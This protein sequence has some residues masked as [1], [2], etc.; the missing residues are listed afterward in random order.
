M[1]HTTHTPDPT[2]EELEKRCESL[3]TQNLEL[4]KQKAE[5]EAKLRW[6]QEQ[7]RLHQQRQFGA[8]SE[9]TDRDQLELNLFNEAETEANPS[10]PEPTLETITYERKKARGH[11]EVLLENLPME[12]I[13]YHLSPEE[14]VCSCCGGSLHEMS[15]EVRQELKIIPAQAKVVKHVR[16]VYACRHCERH[17]T[18]T[19]IVTAPMPTPVYR[20][21]LASPS[22]LAY[23]LHQKYVEGLP[24][25]RQEQEL[26]RLGIPLSRQTLA[27]WVIYG[28][29]TWLSIL[30]DRM[31]VHLK[32]ESVLHGDETTLQVLAEP[33]R[34]A[35]STSYMWL[36]RTAEKPAIVLYDYQQTRAHKHPKAFLHGFQRYLHVDGYAGYH[37]LPGVTLVGCWAHSRREFDKAIKSLPEEQRANPTTAR[38]GLNFCNALFAVERQAKEKELSPQ[39]RY[40]FR[41]EHSQ[42]IL[43]AFSAWLREQMPRVLPKSALGQAIRYC[44][45]QWGKLVA[46][47]KDGRL[48]LDN[49]RAERSIKPF[50][51]GRKNWMFAQ[52]VRGARASAIA[53]S[54]VETAKENG[55]SPRLYLTYVLEKLPN[56]DT[57]DTDQLDNLLPWSPS[58][59]EECRVPKKAK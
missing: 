6:F 50:V 26:A 56:L 59:P 16:H 25:Y 15:T 52:S 46:F 55:L 3:E 11:R 18:E 7:F 23:I 9:K 48:D 8:S 27:N 22:A 21:S 14:Q 28:A 20:G 38:D 32:K 36:Y 17:E 2:I 47:M 40:E 24:L 37:G 44:R 57:N 58:I 45:N 33:G 5:L 10:L 31:H 34:S 1:T 54:L 35:T 53:Y 41:L 19:P 43:D 51:I 13:E 12:T 39:E 49:N 29:Q 42:P 30:Y 4:E